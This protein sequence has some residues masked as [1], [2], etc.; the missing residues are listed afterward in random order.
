MVGQCLKLSSPQSA[1]A[2]FTL[3]SRHLTAQ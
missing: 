2:R 1:T 3:A